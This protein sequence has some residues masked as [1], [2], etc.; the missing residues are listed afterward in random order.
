MSEQTG[1]AT[2]GRQAPAAGPSKELVKAQL[3]QAKGI[4]DQYTA[5][6][7]AVMP[8]HANA[9]TFMGLAAAAVRRDP[10]L[11]Q[12][13]AANPE[14]FVLALRECA[15]LGHVP[16]R[17]LF[18]LI[19]FNNKNAPGGMEVV[20]VEE[21]HGVIERMYRAGG[22]VAIKVNVGRTGDQVLRFNPTRMELPEHEYDEFAGPAERGALK[23]AYAWATMPGGGVSGVAWLPPHEIARRRAYSRSGEAFWGPVGGEGPNTEGMW[24][25][26]AL[27]ALEVLVPVS[28]EYREQLE[29]SALAGAKMLPGRPDP[30]VPT[31][32]VWD[33]DVVEES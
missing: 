2:R 17:G 6:L 31:D 28:S 8:R 20:G 21:Y 30:S 16:K 24:K 9:E 25:K 27:H 29:R 19:P 5:D 15:Y 11:R 3:I 33:G 10:K 7:S 18:D 23:V 32:S 12:A 13:V 22:I 4:L 26:S 14:S 1:G